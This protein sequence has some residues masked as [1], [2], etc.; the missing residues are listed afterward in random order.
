MSSFALLDDGSRRL[1]LFRECHFGVSTKA[2]R[3][4][5]ERHVVRRPGRHFL[6]AHAHQRSFFEG[7]TVGS[8]ST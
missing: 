8:P 5:F 3:P 2:N 7:L 6:D 4:A 1:S